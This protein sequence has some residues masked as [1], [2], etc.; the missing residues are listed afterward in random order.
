MA[1]S[2]MDAFICFSEETYRRAAAGRSGLFLLMFGKVQGIE[3]SDLC[4]F[5]PLEPMNDP[6]LV[7][8]FTDSVLA[9]GDTV[10][11][12]ALNVIYYRSVSTVAAVCEFIHTALEEVRP[13]VVYL[14]GSP[15]GTYVP[16]HL[17]SWGESARNFLTT[18]DCFYPYVVEALSPR[19]KLVERGGR[20]SRTLA[21]RAAG[22]L[23]FGALPLVCLRY[24]LPKLRRKG[25]RLPD[26]IRY[27]F[28]VRSLHQL[29]NAMNI[30]EGLSIPVDQVL[31]IEVEGLSFSG[32]AEALK[33]SGYAV[34]SPLAGAGG[35]ALILAGLLQSY[36]GMARVALLQEPRSFVHRGVS[37]RI[38]DF[39]PDAYIRP[40][41]LLYHRLMRGVAGL[42]GG[43][44]ERTTLFSFEQVSPQAYFD[45]ETL[46]SAVELLF[47]K[48]TMI[49][50]LTL[51]C[52][53]WGRTFLVNDKEE[54]SLRDYSHLNG[55][56]IQY[57]GSPKYS[58]IYNLRETLPDSVATVL[59]ATQPYEPDISRQIL[60]AL[61]GLGE[62]LGFR[63]I[64]RK[65]PRDVTDYGQGDGENLSFDREE[66]PYRQFARADLVVS[67]TST[68]LEE[69]VYIGVPFLS[70]QFS[71]QDRSSS[72]AYLDPGTGLV[73]EDAEQ[74]GAAVRGFSTVRARFLAFR[75]RYLANFRVFSLRDE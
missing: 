33:G 71:P 41:I 59:F 9:T 21:R 52:V 12:S 37:Y 16:S 4:R 72:A 63:T 2:Y 14:Y 5:V 60:G 45:H 57:R 11:K 23:R 64:V 36:I 74:L 24:T 44:A 51:P 30:I 15:A 58:A 13:Q 39:L 8:K 42:L 34:Y 49:Q 65:H 18:A 53:C 48:T 54:L 62:E 61:V 3:E 35:I 32:L 66:N 67:R 10:S 6:E 29:N 46:D 20:W 27:A 56:A 22:W 55:G 68:C 69:C 73:V 17:T 43:S 38:K 47:V 1:V 31:F 19:Y 28:I 75:T 50:A 70:C 25:R 26:T 40:E 7:A